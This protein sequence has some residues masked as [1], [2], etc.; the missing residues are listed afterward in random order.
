MVRGIER[1][2]DR[3][4][5]AFAPRITA[6]ADP[7]NCGTGSSCYWGAECATAGCNLYRLRWCCNGCH[8]TSTCKYHSR[9]C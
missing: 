8:W 3:F 2:A 6:K 7:C 4:L 9:L 1:I 5:D